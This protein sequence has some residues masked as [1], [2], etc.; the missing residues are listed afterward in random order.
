MMETFPATGPVKTQIV[1]KQT[2]EREE[3]AL[4]SYKMI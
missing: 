4:T 2:P 1:G 3:A